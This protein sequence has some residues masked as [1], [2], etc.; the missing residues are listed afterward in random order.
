MLTF[1]SLQVLLVTPLCEHSALLCPSVSVGEE[2]ALELMSIFAQCPPRAVQFRC[3]LLLALTSV[4]VCTFCVSSYSRASLDF[5]DLLLQIAQD[6]SDLHAESAARALRFTACDCL[7]EM[8]ACSPGLLSQRLELLNGLRQ[9]EPSC[10]HQCYVLLCTLVLRNA[11]YQ[12]TQ[13]ANAGAEQLKAL[14][15]GNTSVAWEAEQDP[16]PVK[17]EDSAAL[18]SLIL[19][20][21]G[22]VPTLQTGAD[23]RELRSVLS[24]F[25]E[26]SYLLTPLS[27]AALLHRLTE[28]VS[29]VPAVPP[30]VFRAQLLRLLGTSEVCILQD[31]ITSSNNV[32]ENRVCCLFSVSNRINCLVIYLIAFGEYILCQICTFDQVCLLHST[33]LMK[34]AFTD[35]LFSAEDEAFILKRLVMLSQHPLLSTSE[36]LFYTDCILH[37]PENRPISSSSDG[38][39]ALPVLLTPRLAS[40][41]APTVLDDSVTMLTRFKVLSLVSIE[42]GE[43][44]GEDGK[45]MAYLYDHLTTLLDIVENGGSREMVVTFFRATFLFLV[46]FWPV[47]ACTNSLVEELCNLYMHHCCLAP[48]FINLADQ[49]QNKLTESGWAVRLLGA[50]Q[51]VISKAPLSQITPKDLSWHLKMLARV[52][53]EGQILQQSTLRCLSSFISPSAPPL[54]LSRDWRLGTKLLGVCRRL[55]VH[56]GLDSLLVPLADVLQQLA[57]HYGDTDI[58]DHA[59]LYYT[60]LTTLSREKL[61]GIL[62]RGFTEGGQQVKKRLLSCIMAEGEGLANTLTIHPTETAMLRLVEVRPEAPGGPLSSPQES[63]VQDS[64][65]EADA[66]LA[67]Y[68][69]QFSDSSFASQITLNYQLRRTEAGDSAFD[70]LFTICLHFRLTDNNYEEVSD[71]TVPCLIRERL[72]PEVQLRLKPRQPHPT[73]LGASAIFS[74]QDGLSWYTLLPDVPVAFQ[75]IFRPL[76]APPSWGRGQKLSL[77]DT[78]W[79]ELGS[80]SASDC[81]TSLFCCQLTEAA[82]LSLLHQHLLPFLLSHPCPGEEL[83]VLLFLPPQSHVLLK[84]R[85]E[86]DAVHFSVATDTWHLLPH[87]NSYLLTLTS[88]GDAFS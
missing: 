71:I 44:E 2:T 45:G 86:E 73:T 28:V 9:R 48:H 3:Q 47:E 88:Q 51:G 76:P 34:Q 72:L 10:L 85:S 49:T 61:S 70:Q 84:I 17:S 46:H 32:A 37:F 13:E 60:L 81:A 78:L 23:F 20:P 26:E 6:T 64:P 67:A 21:M 75:Q 12:L 87:V 55:I 66:V 53:E 69:A 22:T 83:K 63:V 11:V 62:A 52:A 24:T 38:D 41:L 43:G 29:M 39:E 36:K 58:Q 15:G 65:G 8:E 16:V 14:L 54:C 42:E 82:L 1:H 33:L 27:Q 30:A 35:S 56:P 19:G 80:E 25:L 57:C 59:R 68:R 7:R 18:F 74:T 79:A 77:F 4:L 50:L 40:A 5:L 31:V